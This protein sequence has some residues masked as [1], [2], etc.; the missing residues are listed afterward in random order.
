MA[1]YSFTPPS[2]V[3]R[4]YEEHPI[5]SLWTRVQFRA[6]ST[7]VQRNDGTWFQYDVFESPTDCQPKNKSLLA[8]NGFSALNT[9]GT[10]SSGQ[11]GYSTPLRLYKGGHTYV[12]DDALRAELMAASTVQHPAG[13]ASYILPA[14]AAAAFTG[15]EILASGYSATEHAHSSPWGQTWNTL[16]PGLLLT[17]EHFG[18]TTTWNDLLRQP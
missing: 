2:D 12:V 14:P 5:F 17:W 11:H 6:G 13:Y 4:P 10:I 9:E 1:L 7:V 15:D 8:P 16:D 18:G 3:T